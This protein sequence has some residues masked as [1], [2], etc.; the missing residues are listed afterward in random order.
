MTP[1]PDADATL[2]LAL[3]GYTPLP[4]GKLASIVTYLEMHAPPAP[5]REPTDATFTLRAVPTPDFDW[6]RDLFRRIGEDYLWLSRLTMD[7]A[8]LA[9]ILH[10]PDVAVYALEYNGRDEG[11]LELDFRDAPTA[12]L[13]F[14]GVTAKL[15]SSGAG[16]FLMNRAMEHAWARKPARVMV[17][18]CTFDHPGAVGFYMRAGFKPYARAIEVMDDPRRDGTIGRER[19]PQVPMIEG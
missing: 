8:A 5:L 17:H 7:D 10:H 12:E 9:A 6:Y 15:V 19:A 14:L 3:D 18:T 1:H 16:R 4:K 2:P 11:L 13:G